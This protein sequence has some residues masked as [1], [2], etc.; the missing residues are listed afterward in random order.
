[1]LFDG[2]GRNGNRK[3]AADQLLCGRGVEEGK[4]AA[5]RQG[6]VMAR[7]VPCSGFRHLGE[8]ARNRP[9]AGEESRAFF[10]SPAGSV[11]KCNENTGKRRGRV[12]FC[13]SLK[14]LYFPQVIKICCK[15]ARS[16]EGKSAGDFGLKN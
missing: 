4:P 12:F 9:P 14:Y 1:M 10:H 2:E 16:G 8:K 15:N 11:Q 13:S 6:A 3:R 7:P 5:F